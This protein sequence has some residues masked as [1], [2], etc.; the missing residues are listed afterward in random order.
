LAGEFGDW[1]AQWELWESVL[2]NTTK[3]VEKL[4]GLFKGGSVRAFLAVRDAMFSLVGVE[5]PQPAGP[6]GAT[7]S[8]FL[9]S[10]GELLFPGTVGLPLTP[11]TTPVPPTIPLS[12]PA[13][14]NVS[15]R[16][17][18]VNVEGV[19]RDEI[20][21]TVWEQQQQQFRE[22]ESELE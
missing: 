6:V 5:T 11:G 19:G 2:T 21:S 1:V 3:A 13:P 12:P 10:P 17:G 4:F 22:L 16:T 9:A 18:D 8:E 20:L 14:A 15:I 7:L